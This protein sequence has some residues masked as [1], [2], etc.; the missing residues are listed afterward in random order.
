[1]GENTRAAADLFARWHRWGRLVRSLL[2]WFGNGVARKVAGMWSV[3]RIVR[4]ETAWS[5]CFFAIT[6]RMAEDDHRGTA[7]KAVRDRV[8]EKKFPFWR[9]VRQV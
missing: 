5:Q 7:Q 1:L 8:S 6:I 4:D 2:Q 9:G 3:I